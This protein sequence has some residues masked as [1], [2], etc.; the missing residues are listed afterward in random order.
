MSL[1]E[2]LTELRKRIIY[3]VIALSVGMIG[4]FI[5]KGYLLELLKQP[6][7]GRQLITLAPAESFMTVFKVVAI[8]GVVVASPVIIYQIW[9]FVAPGL[10]AKER[11]VILFAAAFTSL[12]FLGGVAFAWFL[13]LPRGLEFL[14]TYQEDIFNQEVQAAP[15]FS[16]VTLFLL[17]FGL[18][19]ELPAMILTLA[20][21]GIVNHKQLGRNRRYA[22]LAG[23]LVS[24][25]LTPGQDAFSMLAMF[26]P[27]YVLFEVSIQASRLIEHRRQKDAEVID[28]G[29]EGE[30]AG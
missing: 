27:F 25:A 5:V 14:L 4:C 15:Y 23:A 29:P 11:H 12:L 9:A 28:D 3:A 2:H 6:L 30:A 8:A 20:R 21:M 17:G 24:A 1:V 7:N 10:K 13:V 26:V 22:V 18:I 19:F 16:F